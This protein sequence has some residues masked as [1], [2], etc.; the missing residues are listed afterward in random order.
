MAAIIT[1][2]FNPALDKSVTVPELISEKKLKCS[3]P[4]YEPGGGGI[5]VARAIKKLGG[6]PTPI[7]LA[8]GFAGAKICELLADDGI[9]AQAINITGNSRENLIVA[10]VATGRQY[11]FDMPGPIIKANEWRACLNAIALSDGV[12]FI[13]VS[14]SVPPGLPDDIFKRLAFIAAKKKARLFVD[15][16]GAALQ[17]AVEAGV[18]M[19]KPNLKELASLAGTDSLTHDTAVEAAKKVIAKYKCQAIVVSMGGN[20]AALVTE[21][22]IVEVP[23]P[24]VK[25]KSTVGAGDSL[26]AGVV[27]GLYQNYS[28]PDAARFGVACGS[29]ATMNPGTELCNR[30]DAERIYAA[31]RQASTETMNLT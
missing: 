7:F 20:G 19:I 5:N 23:Q 1:I 14:G 26:V 3:Q 29:A 24:P 16:S 9:S 13:V 8:G 27:Y 28:L 22:E 2:T 30:A 21:Q 10:D 6:D 17:Q 12:Q 11:L 18:Y 15:T 4:V 25:V 31:I